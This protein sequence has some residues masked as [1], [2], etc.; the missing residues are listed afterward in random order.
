[1][2][3][4]LLLIALAAALPAFLFMGGG[5]EADEGDARDSDPDPDVMDE[6]G[7]A[8]ARSEPAEDPPR[9]FV[10]TPGEGD[11]YFP[12]FRP[13]LDRVSIRLETD[14]A[15]A[16]IAVD[17]AGRPVLSVSEG[18]RGLAM[19]FSGLESVPGSD[20]WFESGGPGDTVSRVSLDQVLAA[21]VPTAPDTPDELGPWL[22]ETGLPSLDGDDP[23]TPPEV[24]S[25]GPTAMPTDPE[26]PDILPDLP[27]APAVQESDADAPSDPAP[28]ALS[29]LAAEE[30]SSESPPAEA[31]TVLKDEVPTDPAPKV[32]VPLPPEDLSSESPQTAKDE[33]A[34]GAPG[35]DD[36]DL[37][38]VKQSDPVPD[39]FGDAPSVVR[40]TADLAGDGDP[41]R[42][43]GV[44]LIRDFDIDTDILYI[45]LDGEWTE[46]EPPI[47][48]SET[49]RGNVLV[50]FDG[51]LTALIWQAAGLDPDDV[52]VTT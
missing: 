21:L 43:A 36:V 7:D 30:L 44:S 22:T 51:R 47:E 15:D 27:G 17:S 4:G 41:L 1:M 33:A 49:P 35:E 29:H 32:V 2:D 10:A 8:G 23:D 28:D 11:L 40:V 52:V 3:A 16:S 18:Q 9:D 34:K 24:P 45:Q 50:R 12:D 6:G 42:I 48:L 19:T 13:G 31:P 20:I 25:A 37:A 14:V 26:A 39:S 46:G 38:E 5:D